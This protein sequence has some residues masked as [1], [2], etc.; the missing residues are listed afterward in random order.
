MVKLLLVLL[1]GVM[2][3]SLP[4]A[5]FAEEENAEYGYGTV[6]EVK[7]DSNEIIVSEYD[8]DSDAEAAITYAIHPDAEVENSDSWKNIPN[9]TYVDIEYVT[10]EKGKKVAHY[11]GVYKPEMEDIEE[12]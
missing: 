9:G 8:W 10:D 2:V 6:I 12:E 5:T 7:K 11:I 4:C 1:V 3:I